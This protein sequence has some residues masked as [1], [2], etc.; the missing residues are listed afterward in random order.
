MSKAIFHTSKGDINVN[1]F[2]EDAPLTVASFKF[3]AKQ[4]FYD[5]LSFHRVIDD[6][7]SQG[8]CPVGNGTGGP[9]DKGIKAFEYNGQ[10]VSYP[11]KDEFQSGRSFDKPGLLAMAN[12]GPNTNGSQFFIT[13]KPTTWLNNKHTIFG[14]VASQADQDVNLSLANGDAITSVEIIE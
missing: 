1:L 6:F 2:D 14:E 5:G 11:F 8:G 9:K 4:G 7:M 13:H 12:A 3:L 10:Q